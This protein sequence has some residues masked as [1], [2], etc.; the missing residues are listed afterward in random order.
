MVRSKTSLPRAAAMLAAGLFSAHAVGQFLPEGKLHSNPAGAG[1]EFGFAVAID[2]EWA[3]VG[4]RFDGTAAS[5]AG[6]AYVLRRSA[7]GW[8]QV[9][10][11]LA[12]DASATD[13]FGYSVAIRGDRI[14]VGARRD[15]PRALN[16][17]S[18]YVFR[19]EINGWVQEAKLVPSD[20]QSGDEFGA[21]VAIGD[22]WLVV[23]APLDDDT[24]SNSGSVY[25]FRYDGSAW[26]QA[27]KFSPGVA[28]DDVGRS[29]AMRGNRAVVGAP[30]DDQGG[31]GAGA[32]YVFRR[33]G[34]TWTQEAKLV[35]SD[36]PFGDQLGI[37]VAIDEGV[38]LAG[39]NRDD[40]NGRSNTGAAVV[41]RLT[42]GSWVQEA[43]LIASDGMLSDFLGSAVAL[44]GD[45]ALVAA[46]FDDDN[47]VNSGTVYV[48]RRENG[49]WSERERLRAHD[50]AAEDRLG[51][52]VALSNG[53][54]LLGA[55]LDD[56]A[57]TSSGS[58]Y[59]FGELPPNAPP[60]CDAGGPYQAE[61]QG[62]ATSLG[63]SGAAS[64]DPDG[65]L[66]SFAWSSDCPNASFDD[67]SSPTP[68]LTIR[69]GG[70]CTVACEV[71]LRVSDGVNPPVSC[72]QSVS[73]VDTQAP[74]L[75]TPADRTVECDGAGNAAALQEWLGSATASDVCGTASVSHDYQSLT[76]ACGRTGRA[77]VTWTAVDGCGN[78]ASRSATF[79]IVDSQPPALRCAESVTL[80]A[81][82]DTEPESIGG[83]E[84][85]DCDPEVELEFADETQTVS[86]VVDRVDRVITRTWTATDACGNASTCVQ[87]IR[88]EKVVLPLDLKP[89]GCPASHN[90]TSRGHVRA[91][92]LGT[93]AVS[94]ADIDPASL[95][96]SRGDCTSK[97]VQPNYG[98]PGPPIS[99]ERA[100]RPRGDGDCPCHES[101]D[102][103]I[104]DLSM[105]FDSVAMGSS[106]ELRAVKDAAPVRLT[107]TGTIRKP[108]S[109]LD[110]ATFV[111][112]DCLQLVGG[113]EG[114]LS[115]T[116]GNSPPNNQGGKNPKNPTPPPAD[117]PVP[118]N[119][120]GFG[121]GM[122]VPLSLLGLLGMRRRRGGERG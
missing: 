23:G 117:L 82:S 34:A 28:A 112:S 63:L 94:G 93:A 54:A 105:H 35:A 85:A 11:L 22:G 6:A 25:F 48:F 102:D 62:A 2:G 5:Q 110:G 114:P 73:I 46:P 20:G 116:P 14:L 32:A 58:L 79:T 80:A 100:G 71:T 86:C 30:G 91:V 21:S 15:D 67:P 4:A 59:A 57:G 72:R 65:D 89:G 36:N 107:L 49:V 9:A 88:V 40:V 47:A 111:A 13:E 69:G 44:E 56:D 38:I 108:G 96:L 26:V 24:G 106:L 119:L 104:V 115:Q 98:P 92:L 81:G 27:A 70:A 78:S 43:R 16:S 60:A 109:P 17:G 87:T 121:V 118:T 103:G 19:R 52:S 33:D 113:N 99:V 84:V 68:T 31:S 101:G 95:R 7:D 39:A 74:S 37:A 76:P 120:C 64:H 18:A 1:A 50:P 3:V 83:P 8:T 90:P 29:M 97:W 45:T 12:S 77:T 66:L 51:S 10:Q 55:P 53:L 122:A 75:T 42:G 61:C 41:F